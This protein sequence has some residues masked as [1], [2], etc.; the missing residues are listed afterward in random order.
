M[1]KAAR[2]RIAVTPR[3]FFATRQ[4]KEGKQPC[5]WKPSNRVE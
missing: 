5:N 3:Q 4:G 2:R 1:G